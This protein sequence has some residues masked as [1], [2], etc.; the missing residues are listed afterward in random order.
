MGRG[1]SSY[2]LVPLPLEDDNLSDRH[3]QELIREAAD[4]RMD[5]TRP[6]VVVPST[7]PG[8]ESGG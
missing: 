4:A 8:I 7:D 6:Y 5:P 2:N 1:T 3:P